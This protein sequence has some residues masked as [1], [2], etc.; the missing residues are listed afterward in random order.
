MWRNASM[1]TRYEEGALLQNEGS[2][3]VRVIALGLLLTDIFTQFLVFHVSV[4]KC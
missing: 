2:T 4:A 3:S 1:R